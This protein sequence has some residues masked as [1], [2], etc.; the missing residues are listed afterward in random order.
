ML[1]VERYI[2]VGLLFITWPSLYNILHVFYSLGYT[3]QPSY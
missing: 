2:E 3:F 1:P